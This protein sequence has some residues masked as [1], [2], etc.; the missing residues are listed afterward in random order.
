MRLADW[1]TR[2]PVIVGPDETVP[3]AAKLMKAGR[4]R[5]LPVV[6]ADEVVGV[7]TDRDLR[8][9]MP[10]DATTLSAWEVPGLLAKLHVSEVMSSPVYLLRE[11][12]TLEEAARLMLERRIGG[13]P[14]LNASG[15]LSGII[16]VTDLLRAFL[17]SATQRGLVEA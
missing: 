8:T 5:R 16:T 4:F 9:A 14:I 7:I 1:M 13:L 3:Q 2:N 11:D 6:R 17:K 12:A 10:S 15:R